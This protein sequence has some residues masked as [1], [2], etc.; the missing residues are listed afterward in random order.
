MSNSSTAVHGAFR[1]DIEGLRAI[2]VALVVM[3]HAGLPGFSG[4]FIGVDVFFVLSGYLITGL[5]VR[6]VRLSGKVDYTAFY[7]RRMRRLLPALAAVT[8]I[9]LVA[10]SLVFAPIEQT[11]SAISAISTSG[12][13]TN[14]RFGLSAGDYFGAALESDPFLHAWSLAVEE[15]FYL[16]WPVL[17]FLIYRASKSTRRP[18]VLISILTAASF[19]VSVYLT[20]SSP[21]W[22][23]F[24]LPTRVWEFGLGG[25]AMMAS[26]RARGLAGALGLST[27]ILCAVRITGTTPFPGLAAAIPVAGTAL[28]LISNGKNGVEGVGR[29]LSVGPLQFVGRHSY[30]LYLWHWPV[31]VLAA[32]LIP[33]FTLPLKLLCLLISLVLAILSQKLVED[34]VRYHPGLVRNKRRTIVGGIALTVT[35]AI[36]SVGFLY[37]AR[38]QANSPTYAALTQAARDVQRPNPCEVWDHGQLQT[39]CAIEYAPNTVALFGDSHASQWLPALR[40][41]GLSQRIVS[42]THKACPS[43]AVRIFNPKEGA[44]FAEECAAWRKKSL[45]TLIRL[46]PAV[47]LLANSQE[48]V[49][50]LRR[51]DSRRRV[52]LAEWRSGYESTIAALSRAGIRVV[53]LRDTPRMAGN[54]PVC[55]SRKAKQWWHTVACD[56]ERADAL[57]E[58]VFQAETSAVSASRLASILDLTDLFCDASTCYA[59]RNGIV[60][61]H[62]ADHITT[63]FA[64]SLSSRFSQAVRSGIGASRPQ[65]DGIVGSVT[66][67]GATGTRYE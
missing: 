39:G 7:A 50:G 18:V 8:L 38:K 66:K 32:A 49:E 46:K 35:C 26:T 20:N 56:S 54:V 48:H 47:V 19:C 2:A 51:K 12:Y 24:S 11:R 23:F 53:V 28:V 6:E 13:A 33:I 61:F 34:P 41:F 63:Q 17:I 4:G 9:T 36:A 55:L 14:I 22:A 3:Y 42:M 60:V 64:R 5:L 31:L 62:D 21:S 58:P 15:Q 43:A 10:G 25:L 65:R 40:E 67:S 44:D 52:S 57:D 37:F 16:I 1:P 29:L 59:E 45:E 27:I 30:S